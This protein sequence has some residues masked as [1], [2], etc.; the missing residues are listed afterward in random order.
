MTDGISNVDRILALYQALYADKWFPNSG[1]QKSSTELYPFR[2]TNGQT[3]EFYNSDDL[4][5][6]KKLGFAIP[7]SQDITEEGV[8]AL[9]TYLFEY[10]N[11]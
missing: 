8:A 6:W 10:Y 11:W 4:R 2:R 3:S 7:G 5:D 1:A 9:E